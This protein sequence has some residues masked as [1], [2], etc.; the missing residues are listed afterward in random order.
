MAVYDP[1]KGRTYNWLQWLCGYRFYIEPETVAESVAA[2][3]IPK[4]EEMADNIPDDDNT[5]LIEAMD[6]DVADTVAH[7]SSSAPNPDAP[8]QGVVQYRISDI[9]TRLASKL[10]AL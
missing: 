4:D 9:L 5:K 10:A 6:V 8:T 2:T 1:A 3:T 7:S